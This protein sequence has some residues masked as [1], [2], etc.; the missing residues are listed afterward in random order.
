MGNI[1]KILVGKPERKSS[2]RRPGRRWEDIRIDL[3]QIGC[4]MDWIH[5]AQEDVMDR[6]CRTHGQLKK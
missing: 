2:L 4:G 6:A 1:F 5:L 3:R